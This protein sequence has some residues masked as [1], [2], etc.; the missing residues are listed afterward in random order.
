MLVFFMSRVYCI[1]KSHSRFA[2]IRKR[3]HVLT[4][5]DSYIPKGL[6]ISSYGLD[7][8]FQNKVAACRYSGLITENINVKAGNL[9]TNLA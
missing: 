4:Y 6:R 9:N 1:L 3:V 2:G 5:F 7:G 8:C